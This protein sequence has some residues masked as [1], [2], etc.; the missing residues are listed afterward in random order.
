MYRFPKN[1]IKFYKYN[2]YNTNIKK[3]IYN[4]E[5]FSYGKFVSDS[6]NKH[7]YN[8]KERLKAIQRF[9]SNTR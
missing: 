4:K 2:M 5:N 7:R 6:D 9:L 1:L 3:Q 8:K